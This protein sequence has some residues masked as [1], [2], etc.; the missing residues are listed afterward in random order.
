MGYATPR[1]HQWQTGNRRGERTKVQGMLP[2]PVDWRMPLSMGYRKTLWWDVSPGKIALLLLFGALWKVL[3]A[4]VPWLRLE[5][6]GEVWGRRALAHV[7][8]PRSA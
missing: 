2:R 1:V 6:M 4:L 7:W 3:R 5:P 8:A